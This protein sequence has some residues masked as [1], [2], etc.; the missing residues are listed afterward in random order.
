MTSDPVQISHYRIE[1]TLGQGGMGIVYLAEDLLLRR[2]VALKF[3]SPSLSRDAD[4]RRRL[5]NEGRAAATL[6]HPNAAVLY[7]VGTEGEDLFLAM[8][9]VPGDTLKEL[10]AEGPLPWV[11]VVDIA[12]GI[13]AALRDAHAK[14]IVHRDIKPQ[15]VRRTPDGRIKVLDFGLAKVLGGSTITREGS[16]MGTVA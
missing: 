10:A 5:L 15:N 13:L 14:G 1:S 11:E 12:L 16:I 7:E 4:A 3:L 6:G 9:Y 2:R 8:E